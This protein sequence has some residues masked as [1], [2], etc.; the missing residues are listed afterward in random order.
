MTSHRVGLPSATAAQQI[1][2]S[3]PPAAGVQPLPAGQPGRVTP[4][5]V[6]IKEADPLVFFVIGDTGGVKT[7]TPQYAVSYAMQDQAIQ[8][9][10]ALH[11]GDVVYFNGDGPE[12]TPQFYEAYAHFMRAIVAIPGNHDGDT[13]DDPTRAPLDTFMAN[14]CAPT[15]ALPPGAEEYGRDTETLPYCDWT[16]DA[17]AVTI[18]GLYTNVPSGGHLEPEQ[19]TWLTQECRDAD[20]QKPLIVA[21]HHPPY[22]IDQHHG[23]SQRMGTALDTA[24]AGAGREPDMVLSG[25]VHDY[26]RFTRVMASGK[27]VPYIVSGNGGYHNLHKLAADAAP[28]QEVMPGVTFEH[29]DDTQWGFVI[30]TVAGGRI[31]GEYVGVAHGVSAD[32]SDA[33]VKPGLDRF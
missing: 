21:L 19:V 22:S 11:V 17:A 16:L 5:Q 23:G 32:G 9:A 14:F 7:P 20:P 13:T 25:H 10:F 29:G 3:L 6:G 18:V 30:L 15:P 31:S 4:A 12:Y 2:K 8:P 24:F 33:T 1:H 28:G 26:Q 27:S